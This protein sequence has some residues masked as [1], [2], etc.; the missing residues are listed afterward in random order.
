MLDK[1]TIIGILSRVKEEGFD[2]DLELELVFI[3][4]KNSMTKPNGFDGIHCIE[5][6]D[7]I[8]LG[9]LK[10]NKCNCVSCQEIQEK[11]DKHHYK[12]KYYEMVDLQ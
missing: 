8:P 11:K 7:E 9:R 5:C 3:S 6:G 1:K 4:D 10:L 2:T 12:P